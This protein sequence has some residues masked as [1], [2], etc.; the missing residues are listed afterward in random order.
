MCNSLFANQISE[1]S[2][3]NV[4]YLESIIKTECFIFQNSY[5]LDIGIKPSFETGL[6]NAAN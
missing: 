5:W 1:L 3:N 2:G 6:Q 4:N